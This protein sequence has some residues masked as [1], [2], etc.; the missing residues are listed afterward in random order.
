MDEKLVMGNAAAA[1]GALAAG[2]NCICG[3]PGTPSS[4]LLETAAA[5]VRHGVADGSIA[6]EDAPHVEWSVNEKVALELAFG[7]SLCGARAL[8]TMKQ[9][10]LNVAADPL[11]T[12]AYLGVKGGL[13]LYVADDPGP[14]SSQTEQDTRQFAQFAKVPVLD[15][16]SPEELHGMMPL[17]FALSERHG[18]PVIVR[19]TTRVC[20]GSAAVPVLSSYAPHAI[21]GFKRDPRWVIFPSRAF[22][23]HA[24]LPERFAGLLADPEFAALNYGVPA[25]VP[26]PGP[27]SASTVPSTPP[28]LSTV[29][30]IGLVAGGISWA[31]LLD[32]LEGSGL[33]GAFD[34]LKIGAPFPLDDGLAAD[35]LASHK[36]VLVFEEL[37]A[38]I[39]RELLRVAGGCQIATRVY[40]RLTGTVASA[41]E[42]NVGSVAASLRSFLEELPVGDTAVS[43]LDTDG[44]TPAEPLV[45]SPAAGDPS[46]PALPR[47]TE[48]PHTPALDVL[49]VPRPPVLCAGCPHRASF[50]AVKK[51]LR[52]RKATYSG[53]IGCYTLG[54]ALPLDMVDS[55]VCMGAGFTVPQ[56]RYWA[57][58]NGIH[59]GFVGDS[60]FFAS[61]LTGVANAVY[62]QAKVTLIVL[63]NAI[64]AMTGQQPHPG[65]G[66]RM[67]YDA[68]PR[69]AA[70][71][72]SIPGVLEALGVESVA[73]VNPLDLPRAIKAVV[74][75][76]EK[77]RVSAVVFKAPC[78][79]V[80]RLRPAPTVLSDACTGCRVCIESI[81]CPALTMDAEATQVHIDEALCYGCLLCTQVCPFSALVSSDA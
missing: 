69:D 43:D 41:G 3:Y 46:S 9:V 80:R 13:V 6:A 48:R 14:I 7:A 81:G 11:L 22:E 56:G 4:E 20:H 54:N 50:Y 74:A 15:A 26:A 62:N 18:T 27:A 17:A 25:V 76:V 23:A 34:L 44:P 60:T 40:G 5:F 75:A 21:A 79:T 2:V 32:A 64:T 66:I 70:G 57:E 42:N 71:A 73:V 10:G 53:D 52:G 55:C 16:A 8:V 63:D 47:S 19:A 51:A 78:I 77:P 30:G 68:E 28:A 1:Y 31:Y 58:P 65:T 36:R 24:S 67:S 12:I 33:T 59:L 37:E 39:E 49:L 29:G 45:E 72:L 38:T 61:A 35:F